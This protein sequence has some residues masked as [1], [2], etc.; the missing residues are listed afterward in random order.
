MRYTSKKQLEKYSQQAKEN[1]FLQMVNLS[2]HNPRKN[3]PT[4]IHELSEDEP[5]FVNEQDE[6][7]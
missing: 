2:D 3:I 7:G 5:D 6:V 4:Y 1:F